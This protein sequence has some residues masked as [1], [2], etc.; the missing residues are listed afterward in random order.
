MSPGQASPSELAAAAVAA[1][2]RYSTKGLSPVPE[3]LS[4]QASPRDATEAVPAA[5]MTR[6][7]VTA[8]ASGAVVRAADAG[9]TAGSSVLSSMTSGGQEVRPAAATEATRSGTA[10]PSAASGASAPVLVGAGID[11]ILMDIVM[12]QDGEFTALQLRSLGFD[13]PIVAAT[14]TAAPQALERFVRKSGFDEVIT[15]PFSRSDLEPIIARVRDGKL[16]SAGAGDP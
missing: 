14:G 2:P 10:S 16:R 7:D 9:N 3:Q 15:K 13:K 12:P 4:T 5:P 11:L 6:R 8:V 1:A